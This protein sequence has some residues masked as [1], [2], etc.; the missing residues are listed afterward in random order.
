MEKI[1]RRGVDMGYYSDV[2]FYSMMPDLKESI[3][4]HLDQI[5]ARVRGEEMSDNGQDKA[6]DKDFNLVVGDVEDGFL[7][8]T[9]CPYNKKGYL[10][11]RIRVG[12]AACAECQ[13]NRGH[14]YN[15]DD[16]KVIVKCAFVE[17]KKLPFKNG[18]T[19]LVTDYDRKYPHIRPIEKV[20]LNDSSSPFIVPNNYKWQRVAPISELK[21]DSTVESINWIDKTNINEYDIEAF[22]RGE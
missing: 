13:F 2:Y 3:V 21:P 4:E 22:N 1:K 7:M 11:G 12:S 16:T 18:D 14:L 8:R 9:N 17:K 19:V 15:H 20:K 6:T 10:C 5:N